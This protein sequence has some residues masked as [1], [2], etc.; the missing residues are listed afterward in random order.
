MC[1]PFML[2]RDSFIA[3]IAVRIFITRYSTPIST[4]RFIT[5]I[6][7]IRSTR[8]LVRV[9]TSGLYSIDAE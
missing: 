6:F 9:Y 2:H 1:R 7:I 3:P 4:I 8:G 5:R